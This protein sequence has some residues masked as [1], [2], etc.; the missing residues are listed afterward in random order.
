MAAAVGVS[1]REPA[2]GAPLEVELL[3]A[4]RDPL[5]RQ[6]GMALGTVLE[7]RELTE[8]AAVGV[9]SK[10]H[11]EIALPD[12]VTYR[13]GDYLSVL[14]LNP[15]AM[16]GRVLGHFGLT[17]D[18]KIMVRAS[19]GAQTHLPVGTEVSVGDLLTGYVELAQP[20]T[21]ADLLQLADATACPPHSAHLRTLA[22]NPARHAQEILEPRVGVLELLERFPSCDVDLACY[23]QLLRPLAPRQYSISSSPRVDPHRASL[24]FAV[25]REP[26]R[27]GHGT[28]EGTASN[29]PAR[30]SRG[31]VRSTTERRFPP[32]GLRV[33][34]RGDDLRRNRTGA[35][36]R[37]PAGSG[38]SSERGAQHGWCH[39][40]V[41]RLPPPGARLP[42]PG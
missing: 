35:D 41:L 30:Q 24:T 20:A 7:N 33:H 34:S 22:E 8:Q 26:A 42:L 10:R 29:H 15:P 12:G 40:V 25:V 27:S 3:G 23:L 4:V 5:L 31:R 11:V 2:A 9:G 36:A 32:A 18:T 21:R 38:T 13:A 17:Y 1:G 16:V 39:C 28:F 6:H 14:P 19:E 37:V